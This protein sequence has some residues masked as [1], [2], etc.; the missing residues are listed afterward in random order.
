MSKNGIVSCVNELGFPFKTLDPFLFCVY[1]K[2]AYPAGNTKMQAPRKGNGADFNPHSAYRMYHGEKIPGFPQHPHRGFETVTATLNGIIDHADS[3]GYGG[4][5]GEGDLQWMTAGAGVVH[6]E[7][8]PLIHTD[9]PNPLRFFQ[10]WLNLP[11]KDKMVEPAFEMHWSETIPKV[12][13][14]DKKSEIVVWAGNYESA[15]GQRPPPN[16]YASQPQNDV[17]I[18]FITLQ[19]GGELTLPSAE[20]GSSTNRVVYFVEG[21]QLG[22]NGDCYTNN[23]ALTLKADQAATFSNPTSTSVTE[24]LILQGKPIGEPVV[25]HGP[26]VMNTQKEIEKT[27]HDYR[28]T[29]FGGWPWTEDDHVFPRDE[30]RFALQKGEYTYPP[31]GNPNNAKEKESCEVAEAFKNIKIEENYCNS[32]KHKGAVTEDSP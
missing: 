4:R 28:K 31:G 21:E 29:K 30:T 6:S 26:F 7:M 20:G 2:D 10:I 11:A 25:K 8:F 3:M 14:S 24:L 32:N 9:K 19:P 13:S 27:F 16:S 12:V 17:A 23:C 18:F 15:C 1:H 22:I 5:Y